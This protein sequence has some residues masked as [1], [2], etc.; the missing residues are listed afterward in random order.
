MADI[1]INFGANIIENITTGMYEDSR[2]VFREF[3]QNSCD[4]IDRAVSEGIMDKS[5]ACV[6]IRIIPEDRKIEIYDNARGIPC[7]DFQ[8]ILADVANSEKTAI[9]DKGFRGIGRL[10][11][12][13]YCQELVFSSTFKGED[14]ISIMRCDAK[15]MR[16]LLDEHATGKERYTALEILQSIYNFSTKIDA[17]QTNSHYFKVEMIGINNESNKLLDIDDIQEYLSFVAPVPYSTKFSMYASTIYRH[18]KDVECPVNDYKIRLNGERLLKPYGTRF[19]VYKGGED[20]IYNIEFNDFRTES[21]E[22]IAWAWIGIST[23]KGT[24]LKDSAMRGI[25]IRKEN[26][27]IGTESLL[28]GYMPENKGS[29]YFVGE[30][31]IASKE[32]IPNSQR[33][34]F[35]ENNMRLE[36]EKK[37]RS[38]CNELNAIRYKG[39]KINS[40][41]KKIDEYEAL[42]F[43]FKKKQDEQGFATPSVKEAMEKKIADKK[44]EWIIAT[45]E[46]D[47]IIVTESTSFVDRAASDAARRRKE[48]IKEAKKKREAERKKL[49]TKDASN[50]NGTK[51]NN[52]GTQSTVKKKKKDDYITSHMSALNRDNKK[53]VRIIIDITMALVE[54]GSM[55]Q[56]SADALFDK[57]KEKFK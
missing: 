18:G 46:L 9:N 47:N 6:D 50:K 52:E 5:D 39:S 33:N 32:L 54:S 38:Y 55:S 20:Q 36:L 8:R 23:F 40:L 22:L 51:K 19:S 43:E 45:N 41:V 2:V 16:R 49:V 12:L 53:I 37:L 1:E 13:A 3:I 15:T 44:K 29:F 35:N 14:T 34:F 17:R 7:A 27:Q 31:H 28:D 21:G 26:I 57:M 4:S 10:A 30:M 56:A 42:T 25:R 11:A 48:D 24:I